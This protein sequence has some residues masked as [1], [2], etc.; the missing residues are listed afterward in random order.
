MAPR[1]QSRG[2][3]NDEASLDPG[4]AF[5]AVE[6][7]DLAVEPFPIELARELH[8]LMLH[9]SATAER[10]T[11]RPRGQIFKPSVIEV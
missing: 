10:N 1:R 9:I 2:R 5:V 7:R 6:R 11:R 4:P 3:P 8:H